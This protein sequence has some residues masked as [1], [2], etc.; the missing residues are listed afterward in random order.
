MK[1]FFGYMLMILGVVLGVYVGFWLMFVGGI[2]QIIEAVRAETLEAMP[3]AM[4]IAR[5]MFAGIVG[6]L[7]ALVLII[8]GWRIK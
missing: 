3:I 2:V 1:V 4:G 5:V 6:F 8:P 7:S